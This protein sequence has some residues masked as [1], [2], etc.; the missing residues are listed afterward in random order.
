MNYYMGFRRSMAGMARALEKIRFLSGQAGR[1]HADTLRDLMR[2][3]ESRDIL[4]VCELAIQATM[5][6]KE[7]GRC[8]YKLRD[9]PEL[10]PD[11]AKPLLLIRGEDGPRF[12]WGKAP[13]L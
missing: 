9:Y 12:Q 2:C 3:H 11:M 6:R 8:V 5:E 4:T 13:L 1:L 7:T 10:N